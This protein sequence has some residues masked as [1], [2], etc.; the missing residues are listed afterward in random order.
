MS[1]KKKDPLRELTEPERRELEFRS[2]VGGPG[3]GGHPR[4]A[5]PGRRPRRRL[6]GRGP[7]GRPPLRRRRLPPG[8][9]LQRRGPGVLDAPPRRRAA[10]DLRPRGD[11]A[12]IAAEAAWRADARGRRHRDL[13]ALDVAAGDSRSPRRPAEGL[14]LHDPPRPPRVRAPATSGPRRL[15]P[16]RQGRARRRKAGPAVVTDPILMRKKVDRGGL[17]HRRG[18]GAGRLVHRPGRAIPDDPLRRPPWRTQGDPRGSRTSTCATARPRPLTLFHL[19]DGHA[20]VNG[21]TT[22]PNAVL[23]PWLKRESWR[24]SSPRCPTLRRRRPTASAGPGSLLAG[25]P[26]RRADAPGVAAVA[27]APGARR[28]GRPQDAR[29]GR[30]AVRPRDHA[31]GHPGGRIV[32]EHGREPAAHPQAAGP[33]RPV[34]D[35]HGPDH[36]LVRGGREAL[37]TR[38]DAVR[39]GRQAD[40][41][42][43]A[44]RRARHRLGGSGACSRGPVTRYADLWPHANQVTH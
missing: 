2:L 24:P 27:D 23:H 1:R 37:G 30:L 33:G 39:L 5:P 34:P 25:G 42:S 32:A 15:V 10:A 41:T 18:D 35:G 26:H 31:A 11:G 12:R 28:P 13:V 29:A 16:H 19:A 43:A 6:P 22:C 17:P 36:R 8:R 20:R 38:A 7:L 14:D 40:G 21:V 44:A 9:P 4:Q 3:R